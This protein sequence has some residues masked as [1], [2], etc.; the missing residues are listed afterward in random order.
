MGAA[1]HEQPAPR[2][3]WG[4]RL[5]LILAMAG[6]AV[7]LGNFLR[8]PNEAANHG[9]GAFMVAYFVSLLLLGLPL[10]WM[11]WTIG[12][13]GGALG[14][15]SCPGMLQSLTRARWVRYAGAIGIVMPIIV[16]IFYVYVE[17][18]TLGYA[19]QSISGVL[20]AAENPARHF[21][22]YIGADGG[23]L[24]QVG[25]S[26]SGAAYGFLLVTAVV[27]IWVLSRGL[28]KGIEVV[29][30]IG[31]PLLVLAAV[32][33]VARTLTLPDVEGRN[34]LDGLAVYW[35]PDW[36]RLFRADAASIWLAAAGQI[37]FTLSVGSG[38]INTYASYVREDEDIALTG[39]ATASANEFCEVILG[40]TLVIPAT[41]LFFGM[42]GVAEY[43]SS[44][45]GMAF[46][47]MPAIFEQMPLPG[48]G[49][50]PASV[51]VLGTLWFGLLFI[52]G[53]T[54][55]LALCQPAMAF[56][57]D[58]LGLTRRQAALAIGTVILLCVQPIV[59]LPGVLNEFNYW[60]G[61]FGLVAFSCLE[62]T[63][64][65]WV[66]GSRRAWEDLHRGAEVRLPGVFRLIMGWVTPLLLLGMLAWWGATQAWPILRLQVDPDGQPY[67]EAVAGNALLG[68]IVMLALVLGGMLLV[69]VAARRG[70][71]RALDDASAEDRR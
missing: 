60:A 20:G 25:W 32:C 43:G 47:A 35:T 64:L 14:Y 55:S 67:S 3:R 70:H 39:L 9:G 30:K 1:T 48:L 33:L 44:S 52:A 4:S 23:F 66:Y 5:G 65:M 45:M 16:V 46:I 27:N 7:G 37:F 42:Q 24:G 13:R 59:L 53:I 10:M 38:A 41:F 6:N 31:M 18:W 50:G 12:R 29:A 56:L 62:V 63:L 2:E 58:A 34:V 49:A 69:A 71:F 22:E 61:T 28:S 68:R 17:S 36:E 40:G 15:S 21:G 51:A 11:E 8:F 26:G 57:Q 54:S 19:V